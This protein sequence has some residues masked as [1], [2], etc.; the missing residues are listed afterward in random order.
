MHVYSLI[1]HY[2]VYSA[3]TVTIKQIQLK[4]KK[5]NIDDFERSL[6]NAKSVKTSG[7][8]MRLFNGKKNRYLEERILRDGRKGQRVEPRNCLQSGFNIP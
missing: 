7:S 2:H 3:G 8:G 1:M 4:E 6:G 5:M